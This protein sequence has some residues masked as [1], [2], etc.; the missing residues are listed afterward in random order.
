MPNILI[1]SVLVLTFLASSVSAPLAGG[2]F[3]EGCF[4][5]KG[6]E[7]Q[8]RKTT[9]KWVAD[10]QGETLIV[11]A[12]I[13]V[14]GK[15]AVCG[16]YMNDR[17]VPQSDLKRALSTA[18]I[19]VGGRTMMKNLSYFNNACNGGGCKLCAP[20]YMTSLDWKSA[21]SRAKLSLSS[22]NNFEIK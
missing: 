17:S 6:N 4:A 18:E 12:T 3:L 22:T 21:Y 14:E 11:Y 20:C 5:V 2:E 10:Q 15:A 7:K 16:L 19:K 8:F 13:N 9:V 1:K